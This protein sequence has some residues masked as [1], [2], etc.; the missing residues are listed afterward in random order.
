MAVHPLQG[1][2]VQRR[3]VF[4]VNKK[5]RIGECVLHETEVPETEAVNDRRLRAGDRQPPGIE[6]RGE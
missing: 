4:Q 1:S 3:V 5:T 2:V 6:G